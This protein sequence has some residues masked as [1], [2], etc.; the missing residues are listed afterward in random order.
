MEKTGIAGKAANDI[1]G[2]LDCMM[3]YRCAKGVWKM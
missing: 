2:I 1:S 3:P